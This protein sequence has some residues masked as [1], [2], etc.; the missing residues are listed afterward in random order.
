MAKGTALL[1]WLATGW[2]FRSSNPVRSEIFRTRGDRLWGS[3]SFLNNGHRVS[4]TVVKPMG[5]KVDH[6]FQLNA[7]VKE[8]VELCHYPPLGLHELLQGKH[9]LNVTPGLE[10]FCWS[11]LRK[12]SENSLKFFRIILHWC[13]VRC[14]IHIVHKYE[15]KI[16]EQLSRMPA[17][18]SSRKF[19]MTEWTRHS[20]ELRIE[21]EFC[22]GSD[23][24]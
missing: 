17:F 5:S 15:F 23:T 14:A 2:T 16:V 18:D 3:T 8:K 1:V 9:Y 10:I 19:H 6:H 22:T 4:F 11:V 21:T 13:F 12:F 7:M 20:L 24:P